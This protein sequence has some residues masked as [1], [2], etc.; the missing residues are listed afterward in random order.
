MRGVFVVALALLVLLGSVAPAAVPES[1]RR[2]RVTHVSD[3][4]TAYLTR[5]RYGKT[6]ES[7]AGRSARF[8][9]VD[10]PETYGTDECY[11]KK[12]SAF[13]TRRLQGKR[14]K[15][16]YGK[17]PVDPYG[18]ALVYVWRKGRMFNAA[19]IRRGFARVSFYSPNYRY[20][21][22]FRRLQ[23][24]AKAAERGLWGACR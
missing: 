8:I 13:T 1:A 7:W 5:L 15:V 6:A 14:V 17:D 23:R 9:G 3:G 18:R 2:A 4:D 20:R 19:L 10:T 16:V 21:R 22:W 24:R 12:A 11:S